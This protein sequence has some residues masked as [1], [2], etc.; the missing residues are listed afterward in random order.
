MRRDFS[1]LAA[2]RF[3]VLVI[4][5]GIHGAFA[6]WEAA[7]RG[8]RV[9]LVERNDFASGTSANSLKIAH[10]GLRYLQRL[11]IGRMRRS[12]AERST[13]IRLAPHLVRPLPF[14]VG[15]RGAGRESRIAYRAALTL[16]D[17]ITWDRN[18]G[19]PAAVR[20]PPGRLL[21][22][23]E[24]LGW[25]PGFD[26]PSLSGGALWYDGQIRHP[27]RLVMG[28]VLAAAEAGTTVANY[29]EAVELRTENGRIAGALVADR[30][31][32]SSVAVRARAVINAAG[33]WADQVGPSPRGSA[34]RRHAR[35]M[36]LVLRRHVADCAVGFR[37]R[38]G[39]AED[40]I[41]GG[42]RFLFCCPW[43][44]HTLVGTS[45]N[46][47]PGDRRPA[48]I[49]EI[50]ALLDEVNHACPALG[51]SMDEI[52]FYHWGLVPLKDGMEPGRWNALA[53]RS[54][55]VEHTNAGMRGLVT[56][57][58]PKLTTARQV[59]ARAV[60]VAV[61]AAG[62][63]APS[64]D[65]RLPQGGGEQGDE[66]ADTVDSRLR[67]LYGARSGVVAGVIG[68]NPGWSEPLADGV[69]VRRGEVV[70]AVR[71]EMAQRLTDVVFRRTDLGTAGPPGPESLE[72][73][74]RIMGDTLGWSP[75]QRRQEV[76]AVGA[77]YAPLPI[78]AAA[79]AG[80]TR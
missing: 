65:S 70:Y 3:D 68:E 53:E 44:D 61:G 75:E 59:A 41:N 19:L 40:P 69:P 34:P 78:T 43:R 60:E 21:G 38:T 7:L 51:L 50:T 63:E 36:N 12:S 25:F 27:E 32:G 62:I 52:T 5:G 15:T 18:R 48:A 6:A 37:S 23:A 71:A 46:L 33:P 22:R 20:L 2:D 9:A 35:A 17:L 16:N 28:I 79:A 29:A 58:G 47:D 54:G 49:E 57:T 64:P 42:R 30:L 80:R 4:G 13:L 26:E 76:A 31:S 1:A 66:L 39:A 24:C 56:A 11:D 73:A 45:Y 55:I 74:A 8:L 77:A 14:L 67:E 72:A 10:G